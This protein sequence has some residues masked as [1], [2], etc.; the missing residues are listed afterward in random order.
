MVRIARESLALVS[1]VSFVWM[2]CQ[3]AQ[4]VA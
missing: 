1:V 3:V 2:M 4:L